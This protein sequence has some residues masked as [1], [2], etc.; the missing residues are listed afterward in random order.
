MMLAPL[1]AVSF[2]M[3]FGGQA[4]PTRAM[5][6]IHQSIVVR[7]VRTPPAK[8]LVWRE[9]KAARCTAL[10][11]IAGA[12]FI[13]TGSVDLAFTDGRRLRAHFGDDCPALDFYAGFYIRPTVDGLVC[14]RRDAVR[15]RSGAACQI[16]AF[17]RL[18]ARH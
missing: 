10:D 5:M 1:S 11:G 6:T 3:M 13:K 14:A 8:P 2:L 17:K 16:R 12:S 18:E 15:S 9:R 7:V 4:E